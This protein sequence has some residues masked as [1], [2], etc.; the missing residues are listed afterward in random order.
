MS[1]VA[2]WIASLAA[3]A[4][5]W[6][7][8]SWTSGGREPWDTSAYWS[9][10]LPAAYVLSLLIG[11]AF[12]RR[13]WRWPLAIMLVQ[14]PVMSLAAGEVG[15]LAP[16]GAVLLL[17]LAIPGMATAAIGAAMRRRVAA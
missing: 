7:F 9:V 2:G 14:L 13:T 4:A 1:H 17:I 10:Y 6:S 3:G 15:N 8:A 11:F 5:L 12:P 16:L